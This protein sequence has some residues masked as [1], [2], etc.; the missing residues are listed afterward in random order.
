M[1]FLPDGHAVEKYAVA[2][3]SHDIGYRID[4]ET[5]TLTR[6]DTSEEGSG[7]FS[8]SGDTLSFYGPEGGESPSCSLTRRPSRGIAA[9]VYI[10]GDWTPTDGCDGTMPYISVQVA[11]TTTRVGELEFLED[12]KMI[13]DGIAVT[14]SFLD[15]DRIEIS[16]G[17]SAVVFDVDASPGSLS[18]TYQS[19][20][21]E[22]SP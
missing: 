10:L 2:R 11:G 9:E 19:D 13:A 7:R 21:C 22:L 16:D 18:L 17:R 15:S 8:V 14:Y 20:T 12:G 4:G 3:D 6:A 1:A 5:I